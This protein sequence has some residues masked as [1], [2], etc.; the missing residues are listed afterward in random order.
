M[1]KNIQERSPEL[2]PLHLQEQ[3]TQVCL[4]LCTAVVHYTA[5]NN[6]DNLPY[7]HHSSAVIYR[8]RS[9]IDRHDEQL[10]T[11]VLMLLKILSGSHCLPTSKLF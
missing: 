3:L 7:N 9:K 6:S 1:Q 10:Y 11:W 4:W 8:E 5:R 2:N